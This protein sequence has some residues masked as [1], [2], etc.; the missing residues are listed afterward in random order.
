[1]TKL[2]IA[3]FVIN[4]AAGVGVSKVTNDIISNN[5]TVNSTEDRI[6]VAIG[7]VVLGSMI[8]DMASEHVSK[9]IDQM[10]RLWKNRKH[11]TDTTDEVVDG[12]IV[13]AA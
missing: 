8:S 3:K 4:L 12:I 9:S 6:K 7:S 13:E 10:A 2:A 1:M 11:V 5:V